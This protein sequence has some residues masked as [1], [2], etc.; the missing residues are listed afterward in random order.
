M[1]NQKTGAKKLSPASLIEGDKDFKLY[2][3]LLDTTVACTKARKNELRQYGISPVEA[4]ALIVIQ[5][6]GVPST[7]AQIRN[8]VYREHNTVSALLNRME[9][10]GLIS[11]SRD[12]NRKNLWRI[13]LT[14]KGCGVI[15]GAIKIESIHKI[16]PDLSKEERLTIESCLER[17]QIKALQQIARDTALS[18]PWIAR[19]NIPLD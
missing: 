1:A 13:S 9:K 12:L 10:K 16:F 5:S 6:L 14:K 3:L 2:G 17:I 8:L 19:F 4:R 15:N 7:P 11:K 18:S